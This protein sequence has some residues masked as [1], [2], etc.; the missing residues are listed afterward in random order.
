MISNELNL[1]KNVS[2]FKSGHIDPIDLSQGAAPIYYNKQAHRLVRLSLR[3]H[4]DFLIS[5]FYLGPVETKW[6]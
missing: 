1:S 5:R 2:L 3:V 6:I 4:F